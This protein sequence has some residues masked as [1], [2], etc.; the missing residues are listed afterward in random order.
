MRHRERQR[1]VSNYNGLIASAAAP[2]PVPSAFPQ[3]GLPGLGLVSLASLDELYQAQLTEQADLDQINWQAAELDRHA[4]DSL[5]DA[6]A[7][8]VPRR[9]SWQVPL[10]L[11]PWMPEADRLV[12]RIATLDEHIARLDARVEHGDASR[13]SLTGWRR[14]L[15]AGQRARA[16][17]RLRGVLVHVGRAGAD[18]GS[19]APGAGPLLGQAAQQRARAASMR[20]AALEAAARLD[21]T[22]QEIAMRVGAIQEMGFDSLHLAAYFRAHGLP[23]IGSPMPLARGEVAHLTTAAAL[24]ETPAH[25]AEGGPVPGALTG[26]PSWVGWFHV[27]ALTTDYRVPMAVGTLVV[28]N[29]RLLFTSG[30]TVDSMPL[31]SIIEMD[32]FDDGMCVTHTGSGGT[33][34]ARLASP[35]MAAFYINWSRALL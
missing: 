26:L 27:G 7:M 25:K 28:T 19:E 2:P 16:I 31:G 21:A 34:C 1:A 10:E 30:D 4:E 24:A 35:R 23:A 5:A 33:L 6:G 18:A 3:V 12:T 20:A 13:P 17:Q 14:R 8:L 29:Q 11:S 22:S 32:V 9:A 15:A